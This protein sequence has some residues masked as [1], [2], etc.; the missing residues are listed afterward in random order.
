MREQHDKAVELLR[1]NMPMLN[2]IAEYLYREET[3]TG[4]EF[5]NLVKTTQ[6]PE[7]T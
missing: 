6:L 4:E 7:A 3:I 5:M 2:R 1:G